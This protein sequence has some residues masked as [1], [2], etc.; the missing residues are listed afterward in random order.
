MLFQL[1]IPLMS[2][3]A[4]AMLPPGLAAAELGSKLAMADPWIFEDW[5]P[6]AVF[7]GLG[8]IVFFIRRPIAKAL[9][10]IFLA[11]TKRRHPHAYDLM[12]SEMIRPLG[13]LFPTVLL[14][15]AAR[16]AVFI[17]D[18]WI[19]FLIR[20]TD[21]LTTAVAFWLLYKTA[22]FTGVLV[23]RRQAKT[24]MPIGVTGAKFVVSM[25][26]V[27]IVVIGIF[28]LLSL[29]VK[30]VTGLVTGL[31]IGGLAI[32]LAAQDTL[33]NFLGSLALLLDEPFKVGDWISTTGGEGVVEE[34]GLRSSKLRSLDGALLSMPN[35]ELAS[36]VITNHSN[37]ELRR[38]EFT[39][40]LPWDVTSEQF[41]EFRE[42]AAL[43]LE[44]CEAISSVQLIELQELKPEGM[45][46]FV[47][48]FTGPLY[49]ESWKTRSE[50]NRGL[51]RIADDMHIHLYIPNRILL[52]GE[53]HS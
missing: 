17:P 53:E 24:D 21:S 23:M 34:I 50:I 46:L 7:L 29:W 51:M 25:I 10:R 48:Y 40:T 37:R 11:G 44:E 1:S 19:T 45:E 43:M 30:N 12:C 2:D 31:G 36:A 47:R 35:K 13:M 15:I 8:L 26:R 22:M 5:L 14:S 28:V 3:K 49:E 9:L 6:S 32:S 52:T 42:R 4:A 39:L 20:L 38:T 16:L 41:D 27:S 18:P 33:A